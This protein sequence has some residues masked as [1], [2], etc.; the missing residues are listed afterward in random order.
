MIKVFS[1]EYLNNIFS[2]IDYEGMKNL[3]FDVARGNEIVYK[4]ETIS[5][6]KAN[7]RVRSLAFQIL[8]LNEQTV[9]SKKAVKRALKAHGSEFYEVIEEVIELIVETGWKDS[10]FFDNFVD[11]R[12]LALGDKNEFWTDDKCYLSVAQVSGGNHDLSIQTL[13]SGQAFDVKISHYAIKVGKDINL[14]LTGREDWA[15]FVNKAAD[16]IKRQIQDSM[17][18]ET[19]NA[20]ASIPNPS[21]FK[22]NGTLS[23]ATKEAFDEIIENVSTANDGAPVVI[24]GTKSALKQISNFYAGAVHWIADSQKDEMAAMGR[25]GSYE[26]S[27]LLEIPQRFAL[28]D[29]TKKLVD[30]KKILIMPQVDNKFVK[31]VNVGDTEIIELTEKGDYQDD[32]QTHEIQ[33]SAGIATVIGRYFGEWKLA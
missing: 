4:G 17:Y 7:D 12:N 31:Y 9:N 10:E 5:A 8:G 2:S 25:L 6:T 20:S 16:A 18:A 23:A 11:E 32:L 19:M 29:V 21:E 14:F 26:G 30:N 27:V 3:M 24:M 33:Y 15:K 13:A 1:T 22:G 28:N